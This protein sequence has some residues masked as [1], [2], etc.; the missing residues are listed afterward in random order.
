[1][2]GWILVI[3]LYAAV[4]R[5]FLLT[6]H[7]S[8]FHIDEVTL[9]YNAYSILHT[10]RDETGR[11]WPLYSTSFG[12]DRAL[13]NFLLVAGSIT[14]FGLN[15]FAV[16]FPFALAGIGSVY[17]VYL[18]AKRIGRSQ[19][20][21][22]L[23]ALFLAISPWH[24]NIVRAASEAS[25]SLFLILLGHWFIYKQK[26]SSHVYPMVAAIV[27]FLLSV[28]FYHAAVGFL[29]VAAPATALL[30]WLHP[31]SLREKLRIGVSWGLFIL[32]LAA[33]LLF[34][35][36]GTNRFSQVGFH[37]DPVVINEQNKMFYEEGPNDIPTART[38][39][40]KIITYTRALIRNYF[41]YYTV[42]YL[43]LGGGKPPRYS[44]P[45]MGLVY[46]LVLPLV[47]VGIFSLWRQRGL[48]GKILITLF[49]IS[50]VI[51]A[52]TYEY[53]PNVQRAFFM[54]PYL[55]MIAAYG[56]Y[57]LTRTWH[58]R[59]AVYAVY[60]IFSVGCMVYYFHQYYRHFPVHDPLFRNDG[61][62]EFVAFL[63]EYRGSYDY[64]VIT[65][66]PEPPY[67]Y[68][69]FFT[70]FDP[71]RF[72]NSYIGKSSTPGGWLFENRLFFSSER[73]PSKEGKPLGG[74]SYLYVDNEE[75]SFTD[76]DQE[77][78]REVKRIV[79]KDG[80]VLYRILREIR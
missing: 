49:F 8:G 36:G 15:E 46:P 56:M 3:L 63:R 68:V 71:Q 39:H 64:M 45:A 48:E 73:C 58:N 51:A 5:L 41:S 55:E 6:E 67:H 33:F 66:D 7:P 18:L 74:G 22:N 12:L 23:A 53:A 75:C 30:L 69:L 29:I 1:M 19:T 60:S 61:A 57:H 50:P 77:Q 16:R 2:K 44:P 72:Q 78:Y 9:G 25:V 21:A 4:L 43:L 47:I 42:D 31:S 28:F 13:G 17:L 14:V 80:S 35:Q 24:L 54:V 34:G 27:C 76:Q 10:G 37:K 79:R 65:N 62:K 70:G 11:L 20:Y 40:N 38:Y 52:G 32:L 59:V 26:E